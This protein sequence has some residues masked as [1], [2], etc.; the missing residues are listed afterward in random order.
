M[1]TTFDNMLVK[2]IGLLSVE[3]LQTD[4]STRITVVGLRL[5]NTYPSTVYA[6][7]SMR[8]DDGSTTAFVTKSLEISSNETASILTNGERLIMGTDNT[9]LISSDTDDSLDAVISYANIT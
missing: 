4:S 8:D 6:T 5:T 9:L 3:T 1:A 7:V 2:N